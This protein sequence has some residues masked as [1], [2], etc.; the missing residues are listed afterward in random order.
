MLRRVLAAHHPALA[1]FQLELLFKPDAKG[2]KPAIGT[3]SKSSP[4]ELLL[5]GIDGFITVSWAWWEKADTDHKEAL[6]DHK[7][8]H[9][10]YHEKSGQ[11]VLRPHDVEE[12]ITVW[13]R[14]GP[15]TESLEQAER[16]IQPRL[17]M[18]RIDGESRHTATGA[19]EAA[20]NA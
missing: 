3:A 10:D 5:S 19:V 8:S 6:L 13:K 1:S 11:L 12:F 2:P 15:W 16:A 4:R 14:R 17:P 18:G 7:L 20:A 9:F